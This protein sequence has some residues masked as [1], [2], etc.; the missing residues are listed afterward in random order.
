MPAVV[1]INPFIDQTVEKRDLTETIPQVSPWLDGAERDEVMRVLESGWITEGPTSEEF[2]SALNQQIDVP[3]GVFAPNGTLAL[4]LGL[5]ALGIGNGDEVIV[6]DATFIGSAT[7]V[8]MVGAKPVFVDVDAETFQIDMD[9]AEAVVSSATRAVMPVHINGTASPMAAVLA[10]A[11]RHGLKVIEDAAQALGVSYRGRHVGGLGDVGCFSFFADKTITTGEGGYVVCRDPEIYERLQYLRNQGRLDRGSFVH[12]MIGYNFRITALQAAMGLAQL[13]KL[14]KIISRKLAINE[15]YRQALADVEQV[16]VLGAASNSTH[17]PFRCV[18]MSSRA[19]ELISYLQEHHIQ[20]RTF[21]Y[22]LH[23]QPCLIA[24]PAID[25]KVDADFPN[26]I[27]AYEQGV[28]LPVF[29][30]LVRSQFDHI[31]RVIRDF[32]G[33]C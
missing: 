4:A 3:F 30:G 23:R 25:T 29:P 18:L 26:A 27:R 2:A 21:F 7:A 6:P 28:C 12:P 31:V 16:R 1:P 9:R 11:E 19:H 15:R 33:E 22:P 5:M 20:P 24:A 8:M 13:R 32:F 14:D 17:V 10:F